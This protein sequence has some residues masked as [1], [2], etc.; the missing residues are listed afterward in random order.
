MNS[1]SRDTISGDCAF[2]CS[3][4]C[5]SSS[6]LSVL[7]RFFGLQE[8]KGHSTSS[9]GW[10]WWWRNSKAVR[11]M[12]TSGTQDLWTS[13]A[14]KRWEPDI[15][16]NPGQLEEPQGQGFVEFITL[17]LFLKGLSSISQLCSPVFP[18]DFCLFTASPVLP[19]THTAL[20]SFLSVF[21][22]LRAPLV[23]PSGSWSKDRTRW[24]RVR[25]NW[26][27]GFSSLGSGVPQG[28]DRDGDGQEFCHGCWG[29]LHVFQE[30]CVCVC[31][32]AGCAE[33]MV[34]ASSRKPRAGFPD[35]VVPGE[36]LAHG[37]SLRQKISFFRKALGDLLFGKFWSALLKVGEGLFILQSL[38]SWWFSEAFFEAKP[39]ILS[40]PSYLW[41]MFGLGSVGQLLLMM[42]YRIRTQA[43][44]Y[45]HLLAS[46][47]MSSYWSLKV[48]DTKVRARDSAVNKKEHLCPYRAYVV[49]G[50]QWMNTTKT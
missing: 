30:G 16:R 12:E 42:G 28:E 21:L 2:P 44:A 50:R 46:P 39:Q 34:F 9:E 43:Y 15:V 49:V 47:S 37:C 14:L 26:W 33:S 36:F 45:K 35:F 7:L 13:Q 4:L 8:I 24:P 19:L 41:A 31:V 10:G 40:H 17:L 1:S 11:M 25:Q 27:L 23:P 18:L 20:V 29:H 48:P 6:C 32:R 22:P 38:K 3:L 5:T